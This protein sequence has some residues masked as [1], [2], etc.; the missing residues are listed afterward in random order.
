M[1][2]RNRAFCVWCLL[3]TGATFPTLPLALSEAM[4]VLRSRQPSKSSVA[5]G[6]RPE[7]ARRLTRLSGWLR[8]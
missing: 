6:L 5:A 7:R 2:P 4:Q 1:N 8:S 3:A